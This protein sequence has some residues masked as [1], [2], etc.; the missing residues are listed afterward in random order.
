MMIQ[1][2]LTEI[3]YLASIYSD[4]HKDAFGFRPSIDKNW[5]A[6][7]FQDATDRLVPIIAS[8]IEAEEKEEQQ[9]IA[10]FEKMITNCISLGCKDRATAIRWIYEGSDA[11]DAELWLYNLGIY[12]YQILEEVKQAI[13]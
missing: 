10:A 11:N 8:N 13:K 2:Q 3:Q 4:A 9:A 5:T 6:E 7:Q 12:N 1:T